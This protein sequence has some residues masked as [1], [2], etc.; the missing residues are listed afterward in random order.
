MKKIALITGTTQG[1]GKAIKKSMKDNYYIIAINRKSDDSVDENIICD[2]SRKEEIERIS[3]EIQK[4]HIDILI[5]NAGGSLPCK[6]SD[7]KLETII[8]DINLNFIAPTLL[9]QG[10]LP[11]MIR[12]GYGKILNISSISAKAPTPYLHIYSAAKS[13]LDSLTIS[14]AKEYGERNISINSICPGAVD[15]PVSI[16]GRQQISVYKE[17]NREDYQKSMI[18]AT[19]LGRMVSTEEVA[20]LVSFLISD[21]ASAISGQTINI[22][23]TLETH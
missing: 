14:C 15:T 18:K 2:L 23:G 6:F 3:K 5:N 16:K 11:G 12:K 20:D 10:V 1:I 21:K 9:M 8:K 13:A 4:C 17:M 19:G 7:L 22:C